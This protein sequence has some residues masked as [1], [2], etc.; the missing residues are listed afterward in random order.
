[1]LQPPA[2]KTISYYFDVWRHIA[3]DKLLKSLATGP[4]YGNDAIE[5]GINRSMAWRK[6]RNFFSNLFHPDFEFFNLDFEGI[7]KGRMSKL[8]EMWD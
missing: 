2:F 6:N 1:L 7:K 3:P 5:K 4:G 8:S